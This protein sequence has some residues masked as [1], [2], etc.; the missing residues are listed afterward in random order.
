MARNMMTNLSTR[1]NAAMRRAGLVVLAAL[2]FAPQA[3][4]SQ[5]V[6]GPVHIGI[7]RPAIDGAD[8]LVASQRPDGT[9][10]DVDYRSQLRG[11][12]ATA[13]HLYHYRDLASAYH[14]SGDVRYL[15]AAKKAL[16]WWAEVMPVCPNWWYNEIGCPRAV[17]PATVMIMESLDGKDIEAAAKILAKASF[18]QTG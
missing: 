6:D 16:A 8:A 15:E 10:D 7:I 11:D 12:W 5:Q 4:V 1:V 9:W 17:G 18:K 13:G 14:A 3:A 2:A